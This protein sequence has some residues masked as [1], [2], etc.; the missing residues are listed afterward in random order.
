MDP[1]VGTYVASMEEMTTI[2]KLTKDEV[3]EE[4]CATVNATDNLVPYVAATLEVTQEDAIHRDISVLENPI[5]EN[6]RELSKEPN[7]APIVVK[8]DEPVPGTAPRMAA[9]IDGN[10]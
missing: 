9:L 5:R 2:E 7:E 1:E 8:D 6:V 4:S 10:V 3:I